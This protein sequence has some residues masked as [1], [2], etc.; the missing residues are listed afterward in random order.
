MSNLVTLLALLSLL[1]LCCTGNGQL[2]GHSAPGHIGEATADHQQ[3]E[4]GRA[5]SSAKTSRSSCQPLT[6]FVACHDVVVPV[7]RS[8]RTVL[9]ASR[10]RVELPVTMMALGRPFSLRLYVD[11]L[12][13]QTD[14]LKP[15]MAWSSVVS[16][17]TVVRVVGEGGNVR[18]Y[19]YGTDEFGIEWYVG[20]EELEVAPSQVLAS[21]VDFNGQRLLRAVIRTSSNVYY[22]EPAFDYHQVERSYSFWGCG[23]GEI[24]CTV[25]RCG[26]NVEMF[27][28]KFPRCHDLSQQNWRAT[29]TPLRNTL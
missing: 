21:I 2:S 19:R 13:G 18:E 29:F 3:A 24:L 15:E 25:P 5:D 11:P 17:S 9:K 27:K 16:P 7:F 22:V 4:S 8:K 14:G 26:K 1:L 10:Q 23:S 28:K 20:H 6:S 12:A